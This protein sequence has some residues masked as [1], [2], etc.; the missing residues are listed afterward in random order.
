MQVYSINLW[1]KHLHKG[2]VTLTSAGFFTLLFMNMLLM[3]LGL[4]TDTFFTFFFESPP[5]PPCLPVYSQR[6][7][8]KWLLKT[9]QGIMLNIAKRQNK[10]NLLLGFF[11]NASSSKSS[12]KISLPSSTYPVPSDKD[13]RRSTA[14]HLSTEMS[15]SMK[16]WLT[17]IND[18]IIILS[19]PH[20][21]RVLLFIH[22]LIDTGELL[23]L[24]TI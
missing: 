23:H 14:A 12:S 21:F 6:V 9:I 19:L 2:Q 24:I 18:P 13:N 16:A 11:S 20:H 5:F 22:L 10:N 7:S 1:I 3:L 17:V 4:L 8:V 15:R